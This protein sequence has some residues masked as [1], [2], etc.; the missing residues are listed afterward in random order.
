MNTTVSYFKTILN[1]WS[2]AL[3]HKNIR[4]VFILT[5]LSYFFLFKYC[6]IVMAVFEQR[7]GTQLNDFL[8]AVLPAY[9]FSTLTFILTYSAL[10]IFVISN[11]P[12]PKRFIMAMQAYTLLLLMRTITIYLVPLEPPVNM[13]VLV[14]P[15]SN[16][17]MN[18]GSGG[19]IVKDLFFSGHVSA[20]A[21]FYFVAES[22]IIKRILLSLAIIIASLILL[23]HVHYL[24]D[25]VAAPFFSFLAL[26]IVLIANKERSVRILYPRRTIN[27]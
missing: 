24:I 14:D 21:L 5:M 22:K 23:L 8:L 17:F 15:V 26:K 13:I 11:L 7:T 3:K 16:F 12:N 4:I 1:N 10:L 9:D 25:I 2:S 6:R 20:I 27:K 19:Y 18:S